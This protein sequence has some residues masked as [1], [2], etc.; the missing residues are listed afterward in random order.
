MLH[1]L[2]TEAAVA[3]WRARLCHAHRGACDLDLLSSP[4]GTVAAVIESAEGM[5]NWCPWLADTHARTVACHAYFMADRRRA[6]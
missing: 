5:N 1:A 4:D 2:L 3:D 6:A